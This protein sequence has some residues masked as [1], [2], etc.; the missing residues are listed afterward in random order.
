VNYVTQKTCDGIFIY[1]GR[2]EVGIRQNPMA[3]FGH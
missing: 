1:M 2:E 3:L